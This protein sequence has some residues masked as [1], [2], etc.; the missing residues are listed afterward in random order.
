MTGAPLI[1]DADGYMP[2]GRV[3]P[4]AIMSSGGA[5]TSFGLLICGAIAIRTPTRSSGVAPVSS[6]RPT[7][8]TYEAGG[9]SSAMSAAILTRA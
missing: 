5:N 3:R 2:S 1:P 8:Q 7:C 4:R 9:A 6:A